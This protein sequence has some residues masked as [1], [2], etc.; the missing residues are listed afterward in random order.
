MSCSPICFAC[1]HCQAV[2]LDE[3]WRCTPVKN[4]SCDCEAFVAR[5]A[6]L[7]VGHW[8]WVAGQGPMKLGS[9]YE[10]GNLAMSTCV[11]YAYSASPDQI[12]REMTDDMWNTFKTDCKARGIALGMHCP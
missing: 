10:T 11:G 2:H 5:P 4:W 6:A 1:G 3:R 8:Y 12:T 9:I 7:D